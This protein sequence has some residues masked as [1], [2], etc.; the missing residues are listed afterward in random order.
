VGVH[1]DSPLSPLEWYVLRTSR[2]CP[3]VTKASG[4]WVIDLLGRPKT[5]KSQRSIVVDRRVQAV[6]DYMLEDLSRPLRLNEVAHSVNLSASRLQHLFKADTN[7]TAAQYL[8]SLR[9]QRAKQ[10][11]DSTFLNTKE[12]MQRVGMKDESHFVR[13]F[14][15]IYGLP[16]GSY[17]QR[18][19][20]PR[21]TGA[22]S[23]NK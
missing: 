3:R 22:N 1:S 12:I 7:M 19:P 5:I 23:A 11:I 13:E 9:M 6:I 15:R 16:P 4:P 8:K 21:I 10:L 20:A 18:I 17:K 2:L 14:K